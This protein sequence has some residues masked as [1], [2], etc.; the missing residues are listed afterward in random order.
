MSYK[1]LFKVGPLLLHQVFLLIA[2]FTLH[3]HVIVAEIVDT[4]LYDLAIENKNP[5]ISEEMWAAIDPYLMP[6]NH[7]IKSTLDKIFEVCRPI[8]NPETASLA[9]FSN[10]EPAKFSHCVIRYSILRF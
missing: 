9:G 8:I 6:E 5:Y 1:K 7:P 10:P 3:T 2:I 4:G